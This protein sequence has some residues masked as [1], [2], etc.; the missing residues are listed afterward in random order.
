MRTRREFGEMAPLR[1]WYDGMAIVTG[2]LVSALIGLPARFTRAV[3]KDEGTSAILGHA[4][5]MYGGFGSRG[6]IKLRGG[7][8]VAAVKGSRLRRSSPRQNFCS[9]SPHHAGAAPVSTLFIFVS[10]KWR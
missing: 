4:V 5:F 1:E 8:K 3:Q 10:V 2:K 9:R 7:L 6:E